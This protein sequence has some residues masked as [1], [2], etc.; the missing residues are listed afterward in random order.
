MNVTGKRIRVTK[1]IAG[2]RCAVRVE[3]EAV[4]P[5]FDPSPARRCTSARD[6]G[7][8]VAASTATTGPSSVG[9]TARSGT[10]T[11][12]LTTSNVQYNAQ[13]AAICMLCSILHEE[14]AA[15]PA[16]QRPGLRLSGG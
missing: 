5:D 9:T 10:A 4:I 16:R 1:W 12:T 3:A 11:S 13:C 8:V 6:S 2:D 7:A 15:V 14:H